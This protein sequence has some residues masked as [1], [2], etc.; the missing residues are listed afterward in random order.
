MKRLLCARHSAACFPCPVSLCLH[1]IPK[2]NCFRSSCSQ[3]RGWRL[4]GV[5]GLTV[6]HTAGKWYRQDSNPPLSDSRATKGHVRGW[7]GS[8]LGSN[9]IFVPSAW[10]ALLRI[11]VTKT[12]NPWFFKIRTVVKRN[13]S[14]LGARQRTPS[15]SGCSRM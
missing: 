1:Q 7:A 2:R 11:K 9:A 3:K 15:Q 5:K 8:R 13:P 10:V 12:Q 14:A 4:E 6:G